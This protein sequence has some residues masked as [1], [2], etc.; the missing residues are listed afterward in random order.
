MKYLL[1]FFCMVLSSSI[2]AQQDLKGAKDHP[3]I[4]RMSESWIVKYEAKAFDRYTLVTGS[5]KTWSDNIDN[6]KNIEG[7]VTK[8]AYQLPWGGKSPFEVYKNYE[9]AFASKKGKMLFSCFD[10]ECTKSGAVPLRSPIAGAGIS[11][12]ASSDYDEKFGYYSYQFSKDGINYYVVLMT[13]HFPSAEMMAYEVHIIEVEAMKQDIKLSDIEAA[14]NQQGK[15]ALYG[16]LFETGSAQL[17]SESKKTIK[18]LA[19]YLQKN[20]KVNIY[21]TGHTDDTGTY[22]KN[23]QLSKERAIAVKNVL[24][25][26]YNIAASRLQAVG[27]GPAAP[28]ANNSNDAGRQQNRRV[29]IVRRLK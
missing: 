19:D 3:L 1:M 8:I 11:L 20:S 27:V 6:T 26:D 21:V 24:T 22:D 25:S 29:E 15:I 16:I 5:Q 10:N 4:P 17:K 23:V 7:K 9:N 13:G 18:L 28:V 12:H 14:M 2:F